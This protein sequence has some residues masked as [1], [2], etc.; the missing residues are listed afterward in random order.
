MIGLS[1][2]LQLHI[3]RYQ[4]HSIMKN[5]Q[6]LTHHFIAFLHHNHCY[7]HCSSILNPHYQGCILGYYTLHHKFHCLA[8][9]QII[10]SYMYLSNLPDHAHILQF[11]TIHRSSHLLPN[12][13]DTNSSKIRLSHYCLQNI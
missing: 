1:F 5:T 4:N 7:S 11:F 2:K 12:R 9:K 6:Y 13:R 3:Y 10:L 8:W